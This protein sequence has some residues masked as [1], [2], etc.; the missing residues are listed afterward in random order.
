[1]ESSFQ[2]HP[3]AEG[4]PLP[5]LL[6]P[7]AEGF[8]SRKEILQILAPPIAFHRCLVKVAGSVNAALMLSQAIYW[9]PRTKD[10]N[11]WFY[12]SQKDW[13]EETG[14]SRSE[15]EIARKQL[16][17]TGFWQE[18]LRGV[19]AT[20]YFCVDCEILQTRLQ[21]FSILVCRKPANQI[22]DSS[23]LSQRLP[24]N[25][26]KEAPPAPAPSAHLNLVLQAIDE[27]HR[28]GESADNILKRMKEGKE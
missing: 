13:E 6:Q 12:K 10:P 16:K 11:G 23:K 14:L 4:R 22:A 3:S 25:T 20:L 7:L 2:F 21:D 24:E 19:P 18:Q 15:Q 27:S 17:T 8:L 1:M 26:S 5:P 28:T 9:T